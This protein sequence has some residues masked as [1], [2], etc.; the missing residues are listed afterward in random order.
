LTEKN[1]E[2]RL[3]AKKKILDS[4]GVGFIFIMTHV[5]VPM[6]IKKKNKT[7]L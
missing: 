3:L 6:S 1:E 4:A 5:S 2:Q 7:S